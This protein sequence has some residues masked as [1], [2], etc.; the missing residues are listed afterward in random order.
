MPQ[1]SFADNHATST[2][3]IA[4]ER[5]V[6]LEHILYRRWRCART[7][8]GGDGRGVAAVAALRI[9]PCE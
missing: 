9:L 1:H 2:T 7:R 8:G 5:P 4:I 3:T 6:F